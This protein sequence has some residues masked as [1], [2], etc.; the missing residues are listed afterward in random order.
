MAGRSIYQ[1]VRTEVKKQLNHLVELVGMEPAIRVSTP[2][3]V[4]EAEAG[5]REALAEH[6]FHVVQETDVKE[7]H[8]HYNLEYPE[9]RI[10]KV[11][12]AE[13]LRDCPMANGALATDPGTSVF[14]P[15]SVIIYELDGETR[16]SAIRPSTLLALFTDPDLQDTIRGLEGFLWSAL[17]EGV[18]DAEVLSDEPPLPPGENERRATI[19]KR[20]NLLLTL[21]DA[22]YSIHVSTELPRREAERALRD[23]LAK[24]GQHVLGEV[25]AQ[26]VRILLAVNPG[27]AHKLLAIE[28]DVGVFAPLSVGVYEEGGRTHVRAVRPSTLLIFYTDPDLQDVLLEIEMLLWNALVDLPDIEVHSRQ[29]PLP[30]GT[31]QRTTAAGLS[32]G[33]GSVRKYRPQ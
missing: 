33:L 13:D 28:P 24:R 18:P 15:P 12:R 27:Q 14:L 7:I 32:G 3:S 4:A 26:D 17:T 6:G 30:P 21:V 2:V 1:V 22:E 23:G 5:L 16:V 8:E 19:K 20:L 9:F 29:P 11:A 10:L 31:G 25:D